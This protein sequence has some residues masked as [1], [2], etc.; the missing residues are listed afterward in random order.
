MD[1]K[2]GESLFSLELI[3]DFRKVLHVV[4]FVS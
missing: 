2:T 1:A 3:L 4:G